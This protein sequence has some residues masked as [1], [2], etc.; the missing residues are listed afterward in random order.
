MRNQ[1]STTLKPVPPSLQEQARR[2][3][4]ETRM[5]ELDPVALDEFTRY[6]DHATIEEMVS[7][8]GLAYVLTVATNYAAEAGQD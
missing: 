1:N 4:G 8:R 5:R 6:Q 2:I 3:L 7:R